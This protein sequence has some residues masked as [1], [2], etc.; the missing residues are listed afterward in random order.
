MLATVFQL[1]NDVTLIAV[2]APVLL[3]AAP[4]L[5]ARASVLLIRTHKL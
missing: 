2:L 1:L 4:A 3:I 5:V